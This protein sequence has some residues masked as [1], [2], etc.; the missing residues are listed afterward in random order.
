MMTRITLQRL[1]RQ[2]ITATHR[3]TEFKN[4]DVASQ[5]R[6]R[7][8]IEAQEKIFEGAMPIWISVLALVG[9]VLDLWN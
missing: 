1:T 3:A 8:G 2:N 9:N 6:A 7:R 5:V 4:V